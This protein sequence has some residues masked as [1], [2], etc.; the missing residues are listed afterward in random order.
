MRASVCVFF[1]KQPFVTTRSA[2]IRVHNSLLVV[3]CGYL[4]FQAVEIWTLL[5][6]N[7]RQQLI[8]PPKETSVMS[9]YSYSHLIAV[10]SNKK[11]SMV[12]LIRNSMVGFKN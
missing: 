10:L 2:V 1:L 12:L 3:L 5:L 9:F 7:G 8:G 4:T 11:K 6:K